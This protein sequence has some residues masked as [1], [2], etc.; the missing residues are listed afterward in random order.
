MKKITVYG[1]AHC[2]D[3]PPMKAL[4]TANGLPFEYADISEGIPQLKAF[5]K[6]RE[7]RAEFDPVKAAGAVGVPCIVVNDGEY[8]LFQNLEIEHLKELVK[9]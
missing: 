1:H 3:C 7:T 5:L 2:P 4:L 6:Y 8:V 9:E